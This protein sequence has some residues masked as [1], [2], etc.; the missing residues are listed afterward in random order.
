MLIFE[1]NKIIIKDTTIK[2]SIVIPLYNKAD[3]VVSTL[4]SVLKQ[5]YTSFEIIIID[6]ASTDNS[7]KEVRKFEDTRIRIIEHGKNLGL[8]A[9]RNTGVKAAENDYVAFLDADDCWHHS[10]LENIVL[11]IE[12]FPKQKIFATHYKENYNGTMFTP[13]TKLP[14]SKKGTFMVVDDF[15]KVNLG[16]LI[17]TQ[18]C[19]VVD[20]HVF[21]TVGGY[22][23]EVTF[24]EDI[25]FFIRCFSVF[26]LAYYNN[27]CHTQNTTVN[28]SLTQSSTANK[29]YPNLKK[30]LGTSDTLDTFINFYLY[31]FCQRLK[32]EKRVNAVHELRTEINLNSLN[33]IQ[34]ILLYLPHPLYSL[35]VQAKSTLLKRGCQPTSF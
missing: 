31:C 21:T 8:S 1:I 18:S 27:E 2:F 35:V 10:F 6:D 9:T 12:K 28:N 5:T 15:F 14:P 13:K 32:T 20:K 30:Y 34:I 7:L 11:L 25:D 23:E 26:D 24:A 19:I 4:K 3:Y 29:K 33:I 22:D 16:R 17:L